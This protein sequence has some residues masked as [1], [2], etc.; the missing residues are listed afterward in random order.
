MDSGSAPLSALGEKRMHIVLFTPS[1]D[2]AAS[3][4]EQRY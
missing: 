3:D 1:V 2:G 4:D